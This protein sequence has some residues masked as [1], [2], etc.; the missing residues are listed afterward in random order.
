LALLIGRSTM[1]MRVTTCVLVAGFLCTAAG[2]AL[3][4]NGNG[5]VYDTDLNVTWYDASHVAGTWAE[6]V[7]WTAGLTVEGVSGWRLPSSKQGP[8]TWGYD[9]TT[10]GGYNI[11]SSEMGHLF[12]AELG[13]SGE[14]GTLGV[15]TPVLFDDSDVQNTIHNSGPFANLKFGDL[16]GD[17]NADYWSSTGAAGTNGIWAFDTTYGGQ[18]NMDK[19][20]AGI[21]GPGYAIAV[22]EGNV[23]E[24]MTL[25]ILGLGGLLLRRR[26]A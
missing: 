22:H 2:A 20:S 3:I 9:G 4:N 21:Y 24:P 1:M 7:D 19:V 14:F 23:P 16:W 15:E 5:L 8:Y 10:T 17:G 25:A 6:A 26:M 18:D 11:T 12:Y 13:N